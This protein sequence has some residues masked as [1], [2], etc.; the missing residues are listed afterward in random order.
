MVHRPARAA[1]RPILLVLDVADLTAGQTQTVLDVGAGNGNYERALTARGHRGAVV[2][3]DRSLGMLRVVPHA[4]RVQADAQR[5]PIGSESFDVVLAL[6]MLYY[7]PDIQAAA[8]EIRRV[9]RRDGVF[10]AMTNSE[11]NLV[12]LRA[13][14][15]AAVGTGWQMVRPADERF[16][17]ENGAA[18]LAPAFASVVRI[19][20][21][22][23]HLVVTDVD[24][25]AGYV[26]SVADYYEDQ[27]AMPWVEVVDRVR[28]L[29]TA[30]VA[31]EGELRWSTCAGAFVCR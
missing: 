6:H 9:L 13:L 14:V 24:A 20:C 10:V 11:T 5:L 12:E 15:E 4:A 19:D 1:F 18:L 7:V 27:I 28:E 8:R 17:L 25:V 30:V 21:P 2:A 29:A 31:G 16:S 26:A 3:L 22:Q 23:T